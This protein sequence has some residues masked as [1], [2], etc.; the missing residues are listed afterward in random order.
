MTSVDTDLRSC[1]YFTSINGELIIL[2]LS[3]VNSLFY[4]CQWGRIQFVND[5]L[6]QTHSIISLQFFHGFWVAS[7]R[8]PILKSMAISHFSNRRPMTSLTYALTLTNKSTIDLRIWKGHRFENTH[9]W[10]TDYFTSINGELIILPLSIVN[11]LFYLNQWW[12][13]YYVS[14]S[15]EGRHIV[16]VWFYLPIPLLRLLLHYLKNNYLTL[17]SKIKVPRRSLPYATHRLM[18]MHPHT[19]YHWPITKG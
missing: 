17:R 7:N 15:N 14:P 2:P 6:V 5:R 13:H 12:T 10:W 11:S 3:M 18:V 9:Q 16:L 1:H 8:R 19:K 4:L